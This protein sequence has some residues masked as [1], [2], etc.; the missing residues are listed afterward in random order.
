MDLHWQYTSFDEL[1]GFDGFDV[2]S[3]KKKRKTNLEVSNLKL[4]LE[5][6][7]G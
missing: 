7:T 3:G 2:H 1:T 5:S 6:N 4:T